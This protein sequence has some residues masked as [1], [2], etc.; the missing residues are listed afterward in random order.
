MK[1][2]PTP[3]LFHTEFSDTPPLLTEDEVAA[4]VPAGVSQDVLK[5]IFSCLDL[6]SLNPEDTVEKIRSM[7]RAING[8]QTAFPGLPNVAAV[9]VYPPFIPV[10]RECLQAQD[11]E[12]VSVAAGFPS[13]QTFLEVKIKEVQMAA[14]KGASEIDIVLPLGIFFSRRYDAVLEEIQ[15]VKKEMGPTIL[16]VIL[17]TGVL[18]TPALVWKASMIAMEAGA[19]FIKTSTGKVQ[20]AAT[21]EAFQVMAR[22]I[23]T[24]YE[25][26]G[27]RVGI[28]PAGG[29]STTEEALK[30]YCLVDHVLGPE[31]LTRKLFRIGASRLANVVL[32]DLM[33]S[34]D[35]QVIQDYF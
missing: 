18:K 20:P 17:E 1:K 10:V 9:C 28:K 13:A 22:A 30:Y 2:N 21:P 4:L 34:E 32:R 16:K 12:I 14:E 24:Y 6:T 27:R 35:D 8:F 3:L 33:A 31:W 29:I 25:T 26:T 23:A 11:I 7:C 5:R 15:L 19:D